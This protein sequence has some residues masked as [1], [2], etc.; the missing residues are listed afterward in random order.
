MALAVGVLAYVFFNMATGNAGSS[1]ARP[2]PA[3]QVWSAQHGHC[4]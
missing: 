3:G 2:C 4:H 1:R